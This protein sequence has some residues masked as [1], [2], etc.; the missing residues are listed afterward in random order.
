[1]VSGAYQARTMQSQGSFHSQYQPTANNAY[2]YNTPN[3]MNHLNISQGGIT[4]VKSHGK[5]F[6]ND[7]V[8][9]K[10]NSEMDDEPIDPGYDDLED[11]QSH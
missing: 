3:K 9:S 1:M 2:G 5:A 11:D 7:P 8:Q 6:G 4:S 10:A